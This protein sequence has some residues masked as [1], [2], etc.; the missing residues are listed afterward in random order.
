M[1]RLY[2]HCVSAN[3]VQKGKERLWKPV[4]DCSSGLNC[5]MTFCLKLLQWQPTVVHPQLGAGGEL[6]RRLWSLILYRRKQSVTAYSHRI[7]LA[8]SSRSAGQQG[9]KSCTCHQCCAHQCARWRGE[10]SVE[11]PRAVVPFS[12]TAKMQHKMQ[13]SLAKKIAAVLFKGHSCF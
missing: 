8:V 1:F 7:T 9:C 6:A 13:H 10:T 4:L 12:G 2:P 11:P 3:I 5:S